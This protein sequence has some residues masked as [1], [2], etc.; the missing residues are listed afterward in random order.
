[1][2][3]WSFHPK[4]LNQ[5]Y[6]NAV[7]YEGIVKAQSGLQ[8]KG[9]KNH[10]GL[11]RFRSAEN[12]IPPLMLLAQYLHVIWWEA[13]VRNYNYDTTKIIGPLPVKVI[14]LTVTRGQLKYEW[15]LYLSKIKE[16]DPDWY[17]KSKDINEPQPHPMFYVVEGE[18]EDWE[19]V[20]YFE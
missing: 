1:M 13:L 20:K 10:S 15:Q 17:E 14:K 11:I 9:Y 8:D 7:W 3:L 5:K 6:L 16:N 4:Y 18:I 12:E 19:R 2:R